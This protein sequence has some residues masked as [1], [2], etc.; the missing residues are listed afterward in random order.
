MIKKVPIPKSDHN[1]ELFIDKSLHEL[2]HGIRDGP[3]Q[4]HFAYSFHHRN[5]HNPHEREGQERTAGSGHSQDE[6]ASREK[7]RS[8]HSSND[9]KLQWPSAS[10]FS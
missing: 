10:P 5:G 1:A 2:N 9:D 7:S 8:Y 6:G 3:E 4:Y